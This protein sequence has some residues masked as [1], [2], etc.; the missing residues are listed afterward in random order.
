MDKH[1]VKLNIS[2]YL[3]DLRKCYGMFM[4]KGI[5]G[6]EGSEERQDAKFHFREFI[7]ETERKSADL[8]PSSLNVISRFKT[9]TLEC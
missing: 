2:F 9:C 4:E 8:I 3:L 5:K 1:F 7:T 6:Q